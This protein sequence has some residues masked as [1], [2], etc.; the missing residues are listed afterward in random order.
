MSLHYVYTYVMENLYLHVMP[1]NVHKSKVLWDISKTSSHVFRCHARDWSLRFWFDFSAVVCLEKGRTKPAHWKCLDRI[2]DQSTET[3]CPSSTAVPWASFA[4]QQILAHLGIAIMGASSRAP[5]C[6]KPQ[7][8]VGWAPFHPASGA[9]GRTPSCLLASGV[10]T[11]LAHIPTWQ[12]KDGCC[13]PYYK[14]GK[15]FSSSLGGR[16]RAWFHTHHTG[17]NMPATLPDLFCRAA[18]PDI[19]PKAKQSVTA[20]GVPSNHSSNKPFPPGFFPAWGKSQTTMDFSASTYKRCNSY[21]L[22]ETT[23]TCSGLDFVLTIPYS[24]CKSFLEVFFPFHW[25]RQGL[26]N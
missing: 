19:S 2:W 13:H 16:V 9:V 26:H 3:R 15:L 20:P 6:G 23:S 17:M 8:H 7:A 18:L 14:T 25:Q 12:G 1:K 10:F 4:K 5:G 21:S 11:C 24:L 22:S